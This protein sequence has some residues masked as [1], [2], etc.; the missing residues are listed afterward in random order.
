MSN[1]KF[2]H[3]KWKI[4]QGLPLQRTKFG[5]WQTLSKKIFVLPWLVILGEGPRGPQW[6]TGSHLKLSATSDHFTGGFE[7]LSC[8][9]HLQWET[10]INIKNQ[11]VWFRVKFCQINFQNAKKISKFWTNITFS[12]IFRSLLLTV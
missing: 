9:S 7:L 3:L 10:K 8:N 1:S 4:W 12:I 5:L 11:T 2:Q 6:S